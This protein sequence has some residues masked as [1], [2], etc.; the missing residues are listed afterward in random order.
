M[1]FV[2]RS[3]F[4]AVLL[5]NVLLFV[6]GCTDSDIQLPEPEDPLTTSSAFDP[7]VAW[8][9]PEPIRLPVMTQEQKMEFREQW[10]AR[11]WAGA[12][13]EWPEL[14]EAPEVDLVAF[15][16]PRGS[17]RQL[18]ECFTE[19]GYPAVASP[20]GGVEFPGGVQA[21][22]Q[23]G[24]VNYTCYA[25]FTPDPVMLRDWND[26]Q[27]GMLYDYRVEW[28]TPCL[29]SFGLTLKAAPDRNSFVN[30]FF[31][32][33][34]QARA[35]AFDDPTIS[36]ANRDEILLACPPLPLDHFYGE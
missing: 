35:W 30:D 29:A 24:V 13:S 27:L 32:D 34:S 8:S 12:Q 16:T 10:L 5:A 20:M 4:L 23:Y 33:D 1:A 36:A 3:R 9:P 31:L 7:A 17:N 19:A 11:Q 15:G 28:L 22:P 14:G 25:K 26:D 2:R 21:S 6:T 18:A